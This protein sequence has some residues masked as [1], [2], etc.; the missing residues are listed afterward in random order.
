MIEIL[1]FVFSGFWH[2]VGFA[3][4]LAIVLQGSAQVLCGLAAIISASR[5]KGE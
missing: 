4:L 1:Q 2:F 3:F 5:G